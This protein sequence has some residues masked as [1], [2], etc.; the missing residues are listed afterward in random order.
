MLP[1]LRLLATSGHYYKVDFETPWPHKHLNECLFSF[2]FAKSPAAANCIFLLSHSFTTLVEYHCD[3]VGL[4]L[5]VGLLLRN[6]YAEL[7]VYKRHHEF[8][9]SSFTP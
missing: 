1:C 3:A 5:T 4:P 6:F 7:P 2:V 9:V 8:D